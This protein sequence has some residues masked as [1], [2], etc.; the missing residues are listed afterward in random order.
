MWRHNPW[1]TANTPGKLTLV[2][3]PIFCGLSLIVSALVLLAH[4]GVAGTGAT[5]SSGSFR[6]RK[7]VRAGGAPSFASV[8][9]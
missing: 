9:A 4:I 6:R 5:P 1:G 7:T 8:R 2:E 3:M